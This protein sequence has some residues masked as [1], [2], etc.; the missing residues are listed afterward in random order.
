MNPKNSPLPPHRPENLM[1]V[2]G[3][4]RRA[5]TWEACF[6]WPG[7]AAEIPGPGVSEGSSL[8]GVPREAGL[9]SGL[10]QKH[11]ALSLLQNLPSATASSQATQS[12]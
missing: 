8:T 3:S 7:K 12:A 6:V 10:P 5:D 1:A 4:L 2:P 9:P 11:V